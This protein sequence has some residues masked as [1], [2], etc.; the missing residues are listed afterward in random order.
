QTSMGRV[1]RAAQMD[2]TG[3]DFAG[4]SG[5]GMRDSIEAGDISYKNVRKVQPFG[6]VVVYA[7]M[8]CKDVTYYFTAVAQMKPDSGAY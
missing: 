1:I 7:D 2:R 3:A 4:M 6:N 8:T 5:G